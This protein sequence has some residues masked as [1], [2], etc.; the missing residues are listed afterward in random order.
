MRPKAPDFLIRPV[1]EFYGIDVNS[2]G[3]A[4][5]AWHDDS[6]PSLSVT[7]FGYKCWS[8]GASG[9]AIS[10]VRQ[11]EDVGFAEALARCE[12]ITGGGGNGRSPSRTDGWSGS[13]LDP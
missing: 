1:L 7:R 13:L 3:K 2:R 9:D 10:L 6:T 8:C 4:L 11:Q 12:E 5:C